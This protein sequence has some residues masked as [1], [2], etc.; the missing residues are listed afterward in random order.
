[1]VV[2]GV[3]SLGLTTIVLPGASPGAIFQLACSS[4]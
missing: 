3:S 1:M 4:G 2:S